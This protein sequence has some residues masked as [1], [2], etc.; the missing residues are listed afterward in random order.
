MTSAGTMSVTVDAKGNQTAKGSDTFAFDQANQLTSATVSGSTETYVYDGDGTRFSRQVGANPPI[1]YVSDIAPGLPMT[2]YDGTR[3][4]VYGLGVVYA[5][6]GSTIEVYHADG[7]GSIRALT[8]A[9]G[10]VTATYRTD[11]WG[12]TTATTGGSTQPLTFT[13]EPRDATGLTYLRARY[14]DPDLGRFVSRDTWLG[15]P[16]A[17]QTQNRYSYATNNPA[18]LTDPSGHIV[19]TFVDVAFIVYDVGALLFGPPKDQGANWLALLADVGSAFVPFVAGGGLVVR[20]ARTELKLSA[21]VAS[22][23]ATRPFVNSPS[24]I[25]WIMTSAKGVPDPQG[26]ANA[27]RWDVPGFFNGSDGT[28]E[29]VVD[30]TTNTIV[31][32]NFVT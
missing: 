8:N 13:G 6:A 3:K 1:R 24:L 9:A 20:A 17:P 2:I 22:H 14:Y 15:A 32:F 29:L 19:D 31:H 25:Q 5:A 16:D 7:L 21:T 18:T 11:E 28:W 12:V 30:F 4:T 27:F 10:T 23:A 26:V